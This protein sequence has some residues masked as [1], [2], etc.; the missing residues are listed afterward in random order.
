MSLALAKVRL[1]GG[2]SNVRKIWNAP[3]RETSEAVIATF[4]DKYGAK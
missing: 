2:K 1:T 4:A 3:D